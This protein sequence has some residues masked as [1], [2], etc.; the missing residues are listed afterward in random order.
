MSEELLEQIRS[1][2][3]ACRRD[4]LLR[5]LRHERPAVRAAAA[6]RIGELMRAP[7]V[8]LPPTAALMA[9]LAQ[10]DAEHPGVA[11]AFW[12]TVA[13][14]F[15]PCETEFDWD[16]V[17]AWML[18]V[19]HARRGRREQLSPVPATTSSSTRRARIRRGAGRIATR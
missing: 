4:A 12:N 15:F 9:E 3:W 11:D 18:D 13:H 19:L 1:D 10:R 7:G 14:D 8:G 6:V 2:D 5:L 16:R 17:K